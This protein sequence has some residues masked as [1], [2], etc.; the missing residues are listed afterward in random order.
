[1]WLTDAR[2]ASE[3]A[4]EAIVASRPLSGNSGWTSKPYAMNFR[5]KPMAVFNSAAAFVIGGYGDGNATLSEVVSV[6]YSGTAS[7]TTPLPEARTF[8]SAVVADD[9]VFVT[10]GRSELFGVAPVASLYSA[11]IN[12]ATIGEW[13]VQRAMP[14][15]R[16]NHTANLLGDFLY[17]VGGGNNGPGLDTV[18]R[19]RVKHAPITQ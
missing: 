5:G 17:V 19:A 7:S 4:E 8:G 6:P 2:L 1:L 16:S 10:G 13:A 14:E 15:P 11:K 12:S 3:G 18:F 9:F